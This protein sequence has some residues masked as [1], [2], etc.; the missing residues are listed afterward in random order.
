MT[1]PCT[2]DSHLTESP[3]PLEPADAGPRVQTNLATPYRSP[4]REEAAR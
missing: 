2:A 1:L 4:R 3:V